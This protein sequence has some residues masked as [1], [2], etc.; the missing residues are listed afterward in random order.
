MIPQGHKDVP[1]LKN[2]QR[3]WS[4]FRE[5]EDLNAQ[6]S[7]I[8]NFVLEQFSASAEIWLRD[9]LVPLGESTLDFKLTDANSPACITEIFNSASE[10]PP[11]LTRTFNKLGGNSVPS[12][13]LVIPLISR[14]YLYGVLEINRN[15]SQPFDDQEVLIFDMIAGYFSIMLDANLQINMTSQGLEKLDLVHEVINQIT[16]INNRQILI[17]EITRLIQNSFGY[18]L[19]SVFLFNNDK[20]NLELKAASSIAKDKWKI[21]CKG[22]PIGE[23]MIGNAA[24]TKKEIIAQEVLREELY[25]LPDTKSEVAIPLISKGNLFGVLDVQNNLPFSFSKSDVII[26]KT[27]GNAIATVIQEVTLFEAAARK[28]EQLSVITKISKTINSLLDLDKLLNEVMQIIITRFK[29]SYIHFYIVH[30]GLKK[31]LYRAGTLPESQ[32]LYEEG[33]SYSL[34][35][36]GILT[37]ALETKKFI[38]SNDIRIERQYLVDTSLRNDFLSEIA[39]PLIH[40]NDPLA[41]LVIQDKKENSFNQEDLQTLEAITPYLTTAIK[42]AYLHHSDQWRHQVA[43]SFKSVV[44]LISENVPFEEILVS[45]L[46]KLNQNLPC[47]ASAIWLLDDITPKNSEFDPRSLTLAET[48]NIR[49]EDL[50]RI[51][52]ENPDTWDSLIVVL[53]SVKPVIRDRS[54][55]IGPLGKL[56][57]MPP[58]YS[59]IAAPLCVGDSVLGVLALAHHTSGR[60]GREAQSMS[61]T[62]ANYGAVAINNARLITNAQEQAWKSSVM[63]QVANTCHDSKTTEDLLDSITRLTPELLCIESCAAYLWN[64][65]EENFELKSAV[66]F[67]ANPLPIFEYGAE[68]TQ[69]LM[70]AY[71]PIRFEQGDIAITSICEQ[72][73]E[74]QSILL[75]P[76]RSR[77]TLLGCFLVAHKSDMFSSQDD[78]ADDLLSMLMGI[79]QQTAVSLDNMSLLEAR[80]EEAYITAVLLKIAQSV[81]SQATLSETFE[82]I[83]NLL[84]VLISVDACA[85]LMPDE[86]E[87]DTYHNVGLYADNELDIPI[88]TSFQFNNQN[89]LVNYVLEHE[90]IA[91]SRLTDGPLDLNLIRNLEPVPY[92]EK[93]KIG[94]PKSL[95]IAFPIILK[96]DILGVLVIRDNHLSSHYFEKRVEL[97][98]GVTQEISLAI[99][100]YYLQKDILNREKLEQEILFARNIQKTFLPDSLPKMP[101]WQI[102][103]RWK[104]ALQVGGDFYDLFEMS[105]NKIAM[106]IADVADKGMPAAL[107]MTVA[108]TLIRAVGQTISDPASILRTVNNLLVGDAPDG[109]FVTAIF[110]IVELARGKVVLSNAGHTLPVLIR[111]ASQTAE[112]FPFGKT[113]LGVMKNVEYQNSE[114]QMNPGDLLMLFTDGLN[115]TISPEDELYG[116]DRLCSFLIKNHQ[117]DVE[118]IV[119]LLEQQLDEFRGGMLLSDDITLICLKRD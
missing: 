108:R 65:Y 72:L 34:T 64:P 60:Y 54:M 90:R 101:G 27:L 28:E 58:D 39:I 103:T 45:I 116:M 66:G 15:D 3:L 56:L 111:S 83:V 92:I 30:P 75:V 105:G 79:V 50:N 9:C 89:P 48:W 36:A 71:H 49:K 13:H 82:N 33:Y 21:R 38:I 19:V 118:Q 77:G 76:L 17:K 40:N 112:K 97:M 41:V 85:I 52:R 22:I 6:W 1:G 16:N 32:P 31:F 47:E 81:V 25:R 53:N 104:T 102:E 35:N 14:N 73:P 106:V 113:A 70:N 80:Q 51:M 119:S 96:G 5:Y 44:S 94:N 10:S 109:L 43:E 37:K 68:F 42:N 74:D 98:N 99:Q 100:N 2:L 67:P 57:N 95:M 11:A 93:M 63:L 115:E 55:P 107:Y 20:N 18:T 8:R 4:I 46:E 7:E 88:Y 69:T 59:S 114:F 117:S 61:E 110:A 86:V 91:F 23:G 12:H 84:P 62:F 24:L 26:L 78:K 29:Y 87:S